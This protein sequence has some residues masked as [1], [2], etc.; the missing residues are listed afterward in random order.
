MPLKR[1]PEHVVSL[2][3]QPIRALP[4]TRDRT[5]AQIPFV[6][7]HLNTHPTVA[8][9]RIQVIHHHEPGVII[10]HQLRFQLRIVNRRDIHEVG[11]PQFRLV[12]EVFQE[13]V[14]LLFADND[15]DA[16]LRLVMR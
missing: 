6:H 14:S 12:L 3:L 9:I 2:A 1:Y 15:S 5:H 10:F 8:L 16:V 4:Q 13:R 7:R 11:I